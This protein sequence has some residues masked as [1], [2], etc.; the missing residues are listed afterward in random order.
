VAGWF[1]GSGAPY[2]AEVC[3]RTP[4][5]RKGGHL[6]VRRSDGRLVLRDS[7]Q[8]APEDEDAFADETRHRYFHCNNLWFDLRELA[9][10]LEERDGV[11]GLPLIRNAKTVDPGD[12]QSP[13]VV[14]IETA[15]GAAIEVFPG[16]QA[17]EVERSRFLPVKSTNDLLALRS[18]A[19]TLTDDFALVLAEGLSS[20]PFVDLDSDYY[21]LVGDFDARFPAGPPSLVRA[22]SITVHGDWTFGADVVAKGE[23]T[24]EADGSPGRISDGSVLEGH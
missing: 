23:V 11:L 22:S 24:V 16:A 6:A 10:R 18:D 9:A 15:M 5:D 13:E 20:A 2:A 12:K 17:L 1:A 3:R 21:K 4:A 8:T 14:Q 19:Y 7:A